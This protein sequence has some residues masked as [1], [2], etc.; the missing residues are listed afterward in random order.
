[1]SDESATISLKPPSQKENRHPEQPPNQIRET[2]PRWLVF[3]GV[4]VPHPW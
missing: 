1:M 2:G 3:F 4:A